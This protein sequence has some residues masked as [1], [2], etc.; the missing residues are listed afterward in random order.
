MPVA[1]YHQIEEAVVERGEVFEAVELD[2]AAGRL[3]G[4]LAEGTVH[5]EGG[6]GDFLR[7]EIGQ[8]EAGDAAEGVGDGGGDAVPGGELPP[9][10]PGAVVEAVG[11]AEAFQHEAEDGCGD[12]GAAAGDAGGVFAD[13]V[14]VE[15]R[16]EFFGGE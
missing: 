7:D 9:F 13:A 3:Q 15:Q 8:G 6:E 11:V 10:G 2:A 5:G 1:A 12:T 16:L 14:A 4:G